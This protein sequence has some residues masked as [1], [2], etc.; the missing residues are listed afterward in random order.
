[1]KIQNRKK[2]VKT[3][4]GKREGKGETERKRNKE[5]SKGRENET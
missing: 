2:G 3:N 5:E 1:M 4:W